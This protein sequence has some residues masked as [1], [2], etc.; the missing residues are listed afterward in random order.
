MDKRKVRRTVRYLRSR[1]F[2][3]A[4]SVVGRKVDPLA[5]NDR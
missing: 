1:Y 5:R 3:R 4:F 2:C